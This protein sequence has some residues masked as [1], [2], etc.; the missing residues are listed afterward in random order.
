MTKLA[1]DV[2]TPDPARCSVTATLDEVARLMVQH[3][4]GEIPIVDGTDRP[5]GVITDRDI[6]PSLKVRIRPGTS[7][8]V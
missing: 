2:M 8:T 5:V 3:D 6:A 7:S 4:C 1:R